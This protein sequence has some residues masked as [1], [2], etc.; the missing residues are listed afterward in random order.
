[1]Q[2]PSLQGRDDLPNTGSF[3]SLPAGD[4]NVDTGMDVA[5]LEHGL[6]MDCKVELNQ[7]LAED[8]FKGD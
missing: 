1:M 3:R 7:I 2:S 6:K 5:R 4:Y 8:T